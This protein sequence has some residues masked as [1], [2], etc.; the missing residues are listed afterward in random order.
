MAHIARYAGNR[1]A[2]PP[3]ALHSDTMFKVRLVCAT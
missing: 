2:V 3:A 1:N